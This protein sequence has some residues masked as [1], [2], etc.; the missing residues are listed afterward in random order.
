MIDLPEHEFAV[1]SFSALH[2]YE[3]RR[4]IKPVV[5]AATAVFP[6]KIRENRFVNFFEQCRLVGL[7]FDLLPFTA[8]H[9]QR[10]SLPLVPSSASTVSAGRLSAQRKSRA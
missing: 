7:T 8:N 10:S 5:E 1:G 3:L 2:Q 9:R 6:D 4:R